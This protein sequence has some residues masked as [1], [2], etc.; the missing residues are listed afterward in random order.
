MDLLADTVR[1]VVHANH[2]RCA[3]DENNR[4]CCNANFR[5][6]AESLLCGSRGRRSNRLWLH[7][8]NWLRLVWARHAAHIG[9]ALSAERAAKRC[10]TFH[11]KL[12]HD[13]SPV[14]S[15]SKYVD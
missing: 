8:R 6:T 12:R 7:L 11:A 2:S 4:H 10:S 9:S 15:L 1:D 14:R 3:A 13:L 5:E